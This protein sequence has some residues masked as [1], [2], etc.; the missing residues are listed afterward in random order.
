MAE[1]KTA[2]TSD[3]MKHRTSTAACLLALF[4]LGGVLFPL[5]HQVHHLLDSRH[6]EAEYRRLM[7]VV[8]HSH[9]ADG[10]PAITPA[11][12]WLW[13][14]VDCVLCAHQVYSTV[15]SPIFSVRIPLCERLQRAPTSGVVRHKGTSIRVRAPPGLV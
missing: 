4:T 5:L 8:N 1:I 14:K 6:K 15:V 12:P 7:V 13:S 9:A 3:L 2:G 11:V 10:S